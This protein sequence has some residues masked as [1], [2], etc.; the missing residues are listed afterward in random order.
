MHLKLYNKN[1]LTRNKFHVD[2]YQI[3]CIGRNPD[4]HLLFDFNALNLMLPK[5]NYISCPVL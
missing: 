2:H 1:A 4:P 3:P 5:T